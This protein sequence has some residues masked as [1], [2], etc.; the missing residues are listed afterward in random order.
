MFWVRFYCQSNCE[1]F[2]IYLP[3]TSIM[4]QTLI[5]IGFSAMLFSCQSNKTD[6]TKVLSASKDSIE[7]KQFNQWKADKEKADAVKNTP[8]VNVVK[9]IA[10]TT[11]APAATPARRRK[12]SKAARGTLIGAGS[13]AVL[14]A[15]I[16]KKNR[17]AGAAVGGVL[18]A[19]VGYGVGRSQDKKDGRY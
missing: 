17:V 8:A 15:I 5:A 3:K 4:K 2:I 6:D 1:Y 19:G 10:Q 13:G 12:L 16:N 9:P 14:G 18:G 7:F 11:S